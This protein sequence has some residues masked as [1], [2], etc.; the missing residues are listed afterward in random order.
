MSDDDLDSRVE[1]AEFLERVAYDTDF[2]MPA[3]P[4]DAE[5]LREAALR[6]RE[7]AR[8]EALVEDRVSNAYDSGFDAGKASAGGE[9]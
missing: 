2:G 8:E 7:A 9:T 6:L 5:K 1:L 3:G 4:D